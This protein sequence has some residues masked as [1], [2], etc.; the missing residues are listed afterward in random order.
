MS[1]RPARGHRSFRMD[2]KEQRTVTF[3]PQEMRHLEHGY[4]VTSHSSQG[5]TADRVLAKIDTDS[6]RSHIY[7]RLAYVAIS[8]AS[9]DAHIYTNNAET[10]GKR[11]A[12]DVSK[13]AA[14]EFRQSSDTE[15][16]RQ[17]IH[18]LRS[19]EQMRRPTAPAAGPNP[20][21]RRSRSSPC[22]RRAG[23]R[24][25]TGQNGCTRTGPGRA[26]RVYPT[27]PGR[28]AARAPSQPSAA[29]PHP[30][31]AGS[32]PPRARRKLCPR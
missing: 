23:L 29:A 8:R 19:S 32:F 12:H 30:R 14:V 15:E 18:A 16:V 21:G 27:D 31:R 25:A 24:R 2:G 17:S 13:T 22:C 9:E 3:D 26:A 1:S 7:T 5:L 6:A 28:C 20:W 11:L 10:L 4:V